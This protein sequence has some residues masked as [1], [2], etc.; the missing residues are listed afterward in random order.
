M[1]GKINK[2]STSIFLICI[3]AAYSVYGCSASDEI[4]PDIQPDVSVTAEVTVT[5][6]PEVT[7]PPAPPAV[8]RTDYSEVKK[9]PE[10]ALPDDVCS[11]LVNYEEAYEVVDGYYRIN[12]IDD[13][14]FLE[15]INNDIR[16]AMDSLRQFHSPDYDELAARSHSAEV[17]AAHGIVADIICRNGFLSVML[18]YGHVEPFT[19]TQ[20]DKFSVLLNN[21]DISFDHAVTLNYD[22]ISKNRITDFS[23]LFYEEADWYTTVRY[24]EDYICQGNVPYFAEEKPDMFTIDYIVYATYDGMAAVRYNAED[25][26]LSLCSDMI[27]SNYREMNSVCSG[28]G[29]VLYDLVKEKSLRTC[30]SCGQTYVYRQFSTSRLYDDSQL[31][32]LNEELDRLYDHGMPGRQNHECNTLRAPERSVWHYSP[33]ICERKFNLHTWAYRDADNNYGFFDPDS[34]DRLS[35]YDLF[36]YEWWNYANTEYGEDTDLSAV[37]ADRFISVRYDPSDNKLKGTF[38]AYTDEYGSVRINI[39]AP[40]DTVNQKYPVN[41]P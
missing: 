27:P 34:Y 8:E 25:L 26:S 41:T 35:V 9:R 20:A 10:T 12:F 16:T 31:Q 15:E 28:S 32:Y 36:G 40:A 13:E 37:S 24:A 22:L 3:A 30:E 2:R 21:Q 17:A 29:T 19:Q 23:D 4:H 7:E 14:L 1:F 11:A 6:E 39:E 18:E 33:D 5:E 38:D